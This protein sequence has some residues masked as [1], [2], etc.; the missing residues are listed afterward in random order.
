MAQALPSGARGREADRPGEIPASGWRDIALRVKE[1]LSND[2]VS[3]VAGGVAF[4]I[5]LAIFPALAAALSIYGIYADPSQA[6][7]QIE[8]V[9]QF[10][11]GQVQEI[12]RTQLTRIAQSSGGALGIGVVIGVL[13]SLW[14]AAKGMKALM[15]ALTITYDEDESRGF[16]KLNIIALA[17]TLG[18]VVF[19]L[20]AL[21]LIAAVPALL[22][23]LGLGDMTQWIVSIARWP[24]LFIVV[25]TVIAFLFRFAPDRDAPKWRWNTPG[26]VIATLLWLVASIAFSIYVSYSS[27][28]NATYGSLAAVVILLLWLYLS[29]YIVLIGAEWNAEMERQTRADT[30]TGRPRPMGEREAYAADTL[31]KS[32]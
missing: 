12:L 13:L 16:I 14:S 28:Y 23:N 6:A 2:N 10:L 17:L 8:A 3:I 26:A 20:I 22:G 18:L 19:G 7:Q 1:E 27:S 21:I 24:I 25:M 11:P 5:F 9:A 30:T 29:A 31:G 32:R 4:Y 15:T